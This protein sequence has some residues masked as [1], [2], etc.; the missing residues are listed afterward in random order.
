MRQRL[1]DVP[2]C[3]EKLRGEIPWFFASR[4]LDVQRRWS[5]FCVV[6]VV[7]VV[8]CNTSQIAIFVEFHHAVTQITHIMPTK[9]WNTLEQ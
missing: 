4:W 7:V 8:S 6:V 2:K 5:S 3:S 1:R 9:L